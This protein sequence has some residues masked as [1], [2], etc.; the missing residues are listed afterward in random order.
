MKFKH[1]LGF[2]LGGFSIGLVFLTFFLKQKKTKFAYGP[3]ARVIKSLNDKPI[4]F[5]D[6][7]RGVIKVLQIDTVAVYDL[8]KN[9][10]V[11][12][13]ESKPRLDSCKLYTIQN[14]DLKLKVENCEKA[15]LVIS[16]QSI[17]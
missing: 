10:N 1:R 14:D 7:V 12:F 15:T 13:S 17:N 4:K 8:L 16:L 3:N 11:N 2:F 6:D 5:S 9:G